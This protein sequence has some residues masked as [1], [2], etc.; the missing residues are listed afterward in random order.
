MEE[1][2]RRAYKPDA[3]PAALGEAGPLVVRA[4]EAAI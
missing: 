1:R 3:R 2:Q 4:R